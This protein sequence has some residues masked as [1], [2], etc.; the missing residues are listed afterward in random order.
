MSRIVVGLSNLATR[1]RRTRVR[2]DEL[3]LLFP[4]CLQCSE[5]PNDIV[6][7]VDNCKRCGKCKVSDL[8]ALSETYGCRIEAAAGGRLAVAK[9]KDT[10]VR[11]V[12][13]VA[14]HKELRQGILASFPKAVIGVVNTWPNGPCKETDVELDE[15]ER[16]IQWFLRQ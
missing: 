6:D 15:V 11:A 14:C 10:G 13:A 9:V 12:V 3:M 1:I 5:C 16:A 8:V 2:S 4:V 7:D